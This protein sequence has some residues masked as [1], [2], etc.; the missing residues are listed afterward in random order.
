MTA[1]AGR[2]SLTV[3]RPAGRAG[4]LVAAADLPFTFQ[5][6]LMPRPTSD[7]AVVTAL[8]FSTHTA[9]AELVAESL[10]AV[11]WLTA[12]SSDR[13][14]GTHERWNR[15]TLAVDAVAMG[16]GIGVQALVAP[17]PREPVRRAA[18]RTAGYWVTQAAAAG[19]LSTGLAEL[20]SGRPRRRLPTVVA[21][22]GAAV[23]GAEVARRLRGRGAASVAEGAVAAVDAASPPGPEDQRVKALALGLG[24][25]G[26]L[27]AIGGIER[28]VAS[29]IGAAVAR[30]LPGNEAL[31]APVGHLAT[32]SVLGFAGKTMIER[33]LDRI[34]HSETAF[35]AA[36]DI[37]PPNPRLSGSYE[38]LVDFTTLSRQGRR[39]VWTAT[40]PEQIETVLGEAPVDSPIR[41]YVGLESAGDD[42]ARIR[43]LLDELDRTGAFARGWLLIMCPTGTGYLNYAASSAFEVLTRGDCAIA[44]IQYAARPSVL[45]LDRVRHGRRVYRSLFAALRERLAAIPEG[46]R[47]RVVLFGE[48]LGSWASQ[49]AFKD[50]GTQGLVD[51]G[52]DH[53]IWIGTPYFSTWKERVLHDDRADV[54]RSLVAVC[55]GRD[56]WDALPVETRER[57]RY[58]MVTHHNDGVALFGPPLAIQA[59]PWLG[60]A[61]PRAAAVPAGMVW[62]PT[63][64]FLQVL[65]DMKNSTNVTAGTFADDGHDYRGSLAPMF[66]AVLGRSATPAQLDALQAFLEDRELRRVRWI[67]RHGGVGESMAARVVAQLYRDARERGEDP[68]ARLEAIVRRVAESDFAAAGGAPAG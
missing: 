22:A 61:E 66:A 21:G 45:S 46:E 36:F 55:A 68:D 28:R 33:T 57:A 23:M 44:S 53:A 10:R 31:W 34:E 8:A 65:V 32:L 15:A 26:A 42:D 54:D 12:G 48:S 67:E 7:Q 52:I 6:T 47:P 29:A 63:T 17:R 49:D 27:T 50:R 30:V 5:R 3:L 64:T 60:G 4:R 40:T 2:R 35:E 59:P 11:A 62:M 58:V 13:H 14:A 41:V 38:S 37:P 16:A 51:D 56:E 1:V 20:L 25:A 24:A 43:L 18:V 39:F 19:A 9:I